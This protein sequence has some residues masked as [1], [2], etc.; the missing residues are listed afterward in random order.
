MI[1]EIIRGILTSIFTIG[2]GVLLLYTTLKFFALC[3]Q[4]DEIEE[5]IN[6]ISQ[7]VQADDNADDNKADDPQR[8]KNKS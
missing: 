4:L 2:V 3:E 5:K 7:H 6:S 1:E 8:Q